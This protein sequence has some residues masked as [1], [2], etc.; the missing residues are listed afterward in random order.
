MIRCHLPDCWLLLAGRSRSRVVGPSFLAVCRGAKRRTPRVVVREPR[1]APLSEENRRQAV[2][3]L[4]VMIG[5]CGRVTGV[6][7]PMPT[8]HRISTGAPRPMAG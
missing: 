7:A 1:T 4:T 8:V 6:G 3:A 2:T 5:Q